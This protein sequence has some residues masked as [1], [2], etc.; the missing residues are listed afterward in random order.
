MALVIPIHQLNGL[1]HHRAVTDLEL[2]NHFKKPV[3]HLHAQLSPD[4]RLVPHCARVHPSINFKPDHF[5]EAIRGILSDIL[6][7]NLRDE[8][9][10]NLAIGLIDKVLS[11]WIAPGI[12]SLHLDHQW[13]L[14]LGPGLEILVFQIT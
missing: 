10:L 4:L 2:L 8:L 7:L 13:V 1:K 14:G 12:E 6:S 9:C 5:G 11:P 3:N